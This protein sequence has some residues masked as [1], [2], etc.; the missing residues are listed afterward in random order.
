MGVERKTKHE[1]LS[2][3]FT[4]NIAT[5]SGR[6]RG[7]SGVVI[8]QTFS[9]FRLLL[10]SSAAAAGSKM[11]LDHAMRCKLKVFVEMRETKKKNGE[12]EPWSLFG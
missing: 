2:Y 10:S 3:S 11:A 4:R 9:S 5:V 1:R 8:V 6:E 12:M 7:R